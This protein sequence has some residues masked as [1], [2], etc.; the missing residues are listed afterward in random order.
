[1]ITFLPL[2]AA[3]LAFCACA[4]RSAGAVPMLVSSDLL[5]IDCVL[6]SVETA[7]ET[8]SELA[9]RTLR[10][11]RGREAGDARESLCCLSR[12]AVDRPAASCDAESANITPG[13]REIG[14]RAAGNGRE[15]VGARRVT[16]GDVTATS[17]PSHSAQKRAPASS[18]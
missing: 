1:M 16:P 18:V 10:S 9:R 15:R 5:P 3:A 13:V 8:S 7:P 6:A 12:G 4:R 11:V 2:R 14:R 17:Y